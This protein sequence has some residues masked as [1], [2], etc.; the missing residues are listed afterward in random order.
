MSAQWLTFLLLVTITGPTSATTTNCT[1]TETVNGV[2]TAINF[3]NATALKLS[4]EECFNRCCEKDGC[5]IAGIHKNVCILASCISKPCPQTFKVDQEDKEAKF[6]FLTREVHEDKRGHGPN[7]VGVK[8]VDGKSTT[9]NPSKTTTNSTSQ[10]AA[11]VN[12]QDTPE[13]TKNEAESKDTTEPN[14]VKS[15][16]TES[17]DDLK[18]SNNETSKSESTSETDNS[19]E[20][21]DSVSK[22]ITNEDA[23]KKAE[24]T[25]KNPDESDED[26]S[27][28]EETN[29]ESND[30]EDNSSNDN[31][32]EDDSEPKCDP[33]CN[34]ETETCVKDGSTLKCI[35]KEGFIET[36]DDGCV[37]KEVCKPNSCPGDHSAC[38]IVNNKITCACQKG[39]R[40]EDGKCIEVTCKGVSCPVHATCAVSENTAHCFCDKD[41]VAQGIFCRPVVTCTTEPKNTGCPE[42]ELC[43][44]VNSKTQC[45]CIPGKLRAKPNGDC[46]ANATALVLTSEDVTVQLPA[47][48]ATM[49][50]EVTPAHSKNENYYTYKWE[51]Q[52]NPAGGSSAVEGLT[53]SRV[54]ISKLVAGE[55][56]FSVSVFGSKNEYHTKVV[57]LKVLPAEKENKAPVAVIKPAGK[58]SFKLPA[59]FSLNGIDSHDDDKIVSYAWTIE[60]R[61]VASS[62]NFVKLV[63]ENTDT[64]NVKVSQGEGEFTFKLEVKDKDGLTG[65]A[66]KSVQIL[67]EDDFPPSAKVSSA[68]VLTLPKNSAVLYG[69]GSKDDHGITKWEWMKSS[70]S[71]KTGDMTGTTT[72][73]LTLAN[74]VE[75]TYTFT[76]TVYDKK[77][78]KGTAST[79]V[80]VRPAEKGP[81]KAD[82]G[83]NKELVSPD[84]S[85]EL[86]GS[87]SVSPLGKLLYHWEQIAGN[88]H[89]LMENVNSTKLLVN[90]LSVG[91]YRFKLTVTDTKNITASDE[92]T[93]TVK[94]DD[95]KP[96]T[97]V[98][99]PPIK[100][101]EPNTAVDI[102]GSNSTDDNKIVLW[103]WSRSPQSPALGQVVGRSDHLPVL[104][105]CDLIVGKYNFTLTV[106]DEK[107]A[108]DTA[109]I[110][111]TVEKNP[112]SHDIVQVYLFEDPT[113]FTQERLESL[114]NI[115]MV[116]FSD[117]KERSVVKKW[118][119]VTIGIRTINNKVVVYFYGKDEKGEILPGAPL[120]KHLR[121]TVYGDLLGFQFDVIDTSTCSNDCSGHGLCSDATRLCTCDKFWM[122]NF[123][124]ASAGRQFS[125]CEWSKI[126][127]GL[128]VSLLIVAFFVVVYIVWCVLSLRNDQIRRRR[129]YKQLEEETG[130]GVNFNIDSSD[131]DEFFKM[132]TRKKS[133][134]VGL[135]SKANGFKPANVLS[136]I[137]VVKPS[138]KSDKRK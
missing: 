70:D 21:S 122:E 119:L 17:P 35:C 15:D 29:D 94:E 59:D 19:A 125:N 85:T 9:S 18:S 11:K 107:G 100:I 50:V 96:P 72:A 134:S 68:L 88:K 22:D 58:V 4:F 102:D 33:A 27:N 89:I 101:Y 2:P 75:G 16:E 54:T 23:D 83:D 7:K 80:T 81:P 93:V 60:A 69:N 106:Y 57:K 31:E 36:K 53:K 124:K 103:E 14:Q 64:L 6:V 30:N 120:V 86:D 78:Q 87:K 121:D 104:K 12:S 43:K 84:R 67:A 65:T 110:S 38:T 76:L 92:V 3:N 95:N 62:E 130:R 126:Y 25:T 42:N 133:S 26:T 20:K 111:V 49:S 66:S 37:A 73:N 135:K 99:G 118:E 8:K 115:L 131:E 77:N 90:G 55:Y 10:P 48:S 5:D 1:K 108:T 123:F 79:T 116:P 132:K 136:N 45:S 44:S 117:G 51:Q 34:E 127:F 128:I 63:G 98:L 113:N 28:N 47:E 56:V 13:T 138:D 105:L 41:Y 61:P 82:A 129:K 74:L 52:K 46:T 109:T 32:E 24:S 40:E 137:N 91:T 112:H 39:Y 97:A 71:P 114:T